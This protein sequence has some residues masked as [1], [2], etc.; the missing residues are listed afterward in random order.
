[1]FS[2]SASFQVMYFRILLQIFSNNIFRKRVM[3]KGTKY[4]E[5]IS[6]VFW[7]PVSV[8]PK[9]SVKVMAAEFLT[10]KG[11]SRFCVQLINLQKSNR[12]I[13]LSKLLSLNY[14]SLFPIKI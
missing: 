12:V 14:E 8:L 10:L 3:N 5:L 4:Q 2:L 6:M 9:I 7:N 11:S 13:F 1:M